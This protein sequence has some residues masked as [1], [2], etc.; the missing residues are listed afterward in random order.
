MIRT[1]LGCVGGRQE[2]GVVVASANVRSVAGISALARSLLDC[3]EPIDPA[4][5]QTISDAL[6]RESTDPVVHA[7]ALW[8]AFDAG[9]DLRLSRSHARS[10][11]PGLQELIH[12]G[13]LDAAAYAL[14]RLKATFPQMRYLENMD[15]VFRHLPP[16]AG[17]GREPFVDDRRSD[18]QTVMTPGADTAVI[19]FCGGSHQLGMP[20]NL[21][22]RWFAQ[23]GSHVIYLRDRQKVGYT[24]GIAALGPDMA[25][26]IEGLTRIVSDIGARHV[27]CLGH[28]VGATGALRYATGLGAERVLAL[29]P[30][31]GGHEYAKKAAPHLPPDGLVW[32]RDLVPFYRDGG[33][34]RTHIV[35]GEKHEGDREQCVRMAGLPGVTVEAL[36]SWES[37]H[38][39]GELIRTGRL[40]QLLG[41]LISGDEEV[42]DLVGLSPLT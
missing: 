41:W 30:I 3:A 35:Y 36:S 32:W 29:S 16:A 7:A 31:T 12:S 2:C 33:G 5:R 13:Q 39:M 19:A 18:V 15:F 10:W 34:V 20:N 40:E 24:G 21:L 11:I 27:V 14:P 4:A 8:L 1:F 37:H 42:V 38:V 17:N 25:T 6:R 22:D 26:T 23:L 28:S 9:A